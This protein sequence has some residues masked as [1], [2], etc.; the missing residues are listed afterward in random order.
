MGKR[1]TL[2]L[3]AVLTGAL[4][5]TCG[6]GLPEAGDGGDDGGTGDARD[7]STVPCD[8]DPLCG[9]PCTGG[10]DCGSNL[11]CAPDGTCRADCTP[12]GTECGAGW[13]CSH[14]RCVEDCP[15]VV[16]DLTPVTPTV[17]LLIDQSG[18][19][20]ESFGGGTRYEAVETALSDPVDGVVTTL[21][22][23]VVFGASLYTSHNG[24]LDGEACP[25]LD[26]VA[27][28]L[29]SADEI[30]ALL[31]ANGPDGDT[32]TGEAIVATTAMLTALPPGP[33]DGPRII[34]LATD[35]EPDTCA[36]P[37]P[38]EGQPESVAATQAAWTAGIR[39]FVLSVGE[40]V[41]SADHLQ[42]LA[43]AGAGLPVDGPTDA[44]FYEAGDPA[45]LAD[46]FR[47]IIGG[48]R[49]CTLTLDGEVAPAD[50]EAGD[51]RMDGAPIAYDATNGWTL[52]DGRTMELHG[53]A[54]TDF[55][56]AGAP[57]LTAEW[58][59]GTIIT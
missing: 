15:S 33:D 56:G 8:F 58:P 32:P 22:S 10:A 46:A 9:D 41:V 3:L 34:V 55:L 25:I 16:V 52:T 42:D 54:C 43:N 47:G 18:S 53:E 36:V 30:R 48:V 21:E 6:S 44:T 35:G 5:S 31:A 24:N 2:C 50:W 28:A 12:G 49:S 26:S 19:M 7:G 4:A 17:V 45:E 57:T 39:T 59:C 20:D 29:D 38:Q 14:G 27:P 1:T 11:Y 13:L 37:N 40:G 23:Q 51:V